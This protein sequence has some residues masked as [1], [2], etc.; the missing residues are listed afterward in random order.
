MVSGSELPTPAD[1]VGCVKDTVKDLDLTLIIEPGRSVVATSA[2]LI[3]QVTG[4]KTNGNKD[5]I[6]IDGSMSTLIRVSLYNAYQLIEFTAPCDGEVKKFD[7]VGPVCE[8]ADFLGKDR[9]LPSPQ[10]G[11]GLAVLDSG[12]YSMSMTSAY[13]L[14]MPPAEYWVED[15]KLRLIR[16]GQ[17]LEYYFESFAGL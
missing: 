14:K 16:K 9:F 2:A 4:C 1:I 15:G 12:A 3:N 10:K 17:T 6:V 11:A 13:N 8:S 5:F 7:I